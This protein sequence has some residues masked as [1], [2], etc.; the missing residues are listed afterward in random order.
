MKVP[1]QV[2]VVRRKITKNLTRHL[3]CSSKRDLSDSEIKNIL[4]AHPNKRLGNLLMLTPLLQEIEQRFPDARVTLF[5]MGGLAPSLF[6]NYPQVVSVL[7]LPGKPFRSLRK[8]IAT[9]LKIH[10]CKYDLV[11]NF[12]NQSSSGTIAT[13]VARAKVRYFGEDMGTDAAVSH[14]ATRPVVRFREFLRLN[15]YTL[16]DKP[17]PHLDI[18]LDE[19]ELSRGKVCVR[20]I[21]PGEKPV[22]SIF[23]YATG[24]KIYD[25]SWWDECYRQLEKT[26][27]DYHFLEIL[28]VENVSQLGFRCPTFYSQDVREIASIIHHTSLFIGADSGIMHLAAAAGT[29]VIGLF[30]VTCVHKYKP[31]NPFSKGVD[32]NLNPL[33]SWIASVEELIAASRQ[34]IPL[35]SA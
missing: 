17:L 19:S 8:Y 10:S 15:G 18:R 29:P 27:P 1:K 35:R 33:A 26:Y 6:R 2:N 3:A 28:P 32:T 22:I 13:R 20:N 7:N 16:E 25:E 9:W 12:Q 5:V 23:T 24:S 30:Q 14:F 34:G 21:F 31:L 11:I 4:I